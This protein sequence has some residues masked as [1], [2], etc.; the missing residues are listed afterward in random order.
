MPEA[1]G[2][3]KAAAEQL[4]EV[5]NCLLSPQALGRMTL[6]QGLPLTK[7]KGTQGQLQSSQVGTPS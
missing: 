3:Y 1:S 7:R 6:H 2:S 4:S 5:P